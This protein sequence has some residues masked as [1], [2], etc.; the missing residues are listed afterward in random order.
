MECAVSN[1]RTGHQATRPSRSLRRSR[2][3]SST[4]SLN[5]TLLSTFDFP[6]PIL[7]AAIARVH[8]LCGRESVVGPE[9]PW[10]SGPLISYCGNSGNLYRQPLTRSR[11]NRVFHF[12]NYI[13]LLS[14][15]LPAGA[16]HCADEAFSRGVRG[17]C[18]STPLSSQRAGSC[19]RRYGGQAS[20]TSSSGTTACRHS[21]RNLRALDRR[22]KIAF[23]RRPRII[24]LLATSACQC[25]RACRRD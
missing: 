7:L 1:S 15:P 25:L 21:P 12:T 14:D 13:R 19:T 18:A 10:P 20:P 3:K 11:R 8:S 17:R 23:R 2:S 5:S 9:H 16:Q 22:R 4:P 24:G 6:L